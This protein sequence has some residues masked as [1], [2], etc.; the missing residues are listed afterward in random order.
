VTVATA[1]EAEALAPV[2]RD[3]LIAYPLLGQSK[4]NRVIQLDPFPGRLTIAVDSLVALGEVAEAARSAGRD[5]GVLIELDVGMK[6][7]GV[8]TIEEAVA[9]AA[10]ASNKTGVRYDGVMF[11]PGH[12][13]SHIDAQEEAVRDV[14]AYLVS[15]R[16]ALDGAGLAPRVVSGGATPTVW[17]SH[18]MGVTEVRA[19]TIVF[20]DRTTVLTGA[21]DWHDCAYS[22]LA[23]VI[24]TAVSGQAVIDAGSKALSKEELRAAGGGYGVVHDRRDI[25]VKALSEEHGV[26]DLSAT[27]WRPAIGERV[28]I[29]PNHVC[30]S[31]NLHETVWAMLG[32]EV[33]GCWPVAA[34]GRAVQRPRSV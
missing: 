24:S 16:E 33:V 11:Y 6:R 5:V 4:L 32:D 26:L 8:P 12:I 14:R 13:R 18:E 30:V 27:A 20:N 23:T 1:R 22:V 21:C 25:I 7:T 17:R 10:E 19:G 28:R 9:L 15:V 31:M 34:R 29:I 2:C 3:I